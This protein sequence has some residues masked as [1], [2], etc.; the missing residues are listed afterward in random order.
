MKEKDKIVSAMN[1]VVQKRNETILFGGCSK[2][3]R[4]T[5]QIRHNKAQSEVDRRLM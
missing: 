5:V 1:E 4:K 3:N 2:K